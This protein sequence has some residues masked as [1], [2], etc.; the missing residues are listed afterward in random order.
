LPSGEQSLMSGAGVVSLWLA[1]TNYPDLPRGWVVDRVRYDFR[2][3]LDPVPEP[4]TLSLLGI[5]LAATALRL[6]THR[7]EHGD[8]AALDVD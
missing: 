1:Q 5:G 3:D 4:A 7:K 2:D 6:R 8:L